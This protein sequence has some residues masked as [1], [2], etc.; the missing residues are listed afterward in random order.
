[1]EVDVAQ[2]DPTLVKRFHMTEADEELRRMDCPERL[3][4]YAA[5]T[6]EF[7]LEG[8]M[9]YIYEQLFGRYARDS[10]VRVPLGPLLSTVCVSGRQQCCARHAAKLVACVPL[11]LECSHPQ[12]CAHRDAALHAVKLLSGL[13]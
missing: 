2:P 9:D 11:A 5:D 13:T 3:Y 6:P 8:A 12:C 1:M 10:V 7:S 4:A